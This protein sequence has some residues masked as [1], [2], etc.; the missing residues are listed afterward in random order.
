[1]EKTLPSDSNCDST[2]RNAVWARRLE[3]VMTPWGSVRRRSRMLLEEDNLK[4][5]CQ[6]PSFKVTEY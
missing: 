5:T 2:S 3:S 1:M 4:T 6:S